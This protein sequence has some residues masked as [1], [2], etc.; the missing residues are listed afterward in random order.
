MRIDGDK[1]D[2]HGLIGKDVISN[3]PKR[4]L[5]KVDQLLRDFKSGKKSFSSREAQR[6]ERTV[7][8]SYNAIRNLKGEYRGLVRLISDITERKRVEERLKEYSE[9]LKEMVDE[10]TQEL[11]GAQEQL[12]R[13]EKLAVLGQLAG[14]VSHELR[15]PLAVINNAVYYL[16]MVQPD[17]DE[18]VK[19]YLDVLSAE[20]SNAKKIISDLLDFALIKSVD[21][22]KVVVSELVSQVLAKQPPPENVTAATDVPT[23]LPSLLVDPLQIE[24][25]FTNLVTNAYQAMPDGGNLTITAEVI[26]DQHPVTSDHSLLSTPQPLIPNSQSLISIFITDSGT[27]I[28]PENMSKLF[29]PLFTTKARGIGLGLAISRNL[30]E[31]NGG[32]IDV[33]SEEDRGSTFIVILPT[34]EVTA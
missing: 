19:E 32:R 14:S 10:R 2:W 26:S 18:K 33:V 23:D 17:A 20:V 21:N 8:I 12:V 28:P 4:T 27:G 16:K 13:R 29:E 11:R 9:R 1:S 5:V 34:G 15:N 7:E 24:Q 22:E 3:H 25:V 6:G 30:V 31:A